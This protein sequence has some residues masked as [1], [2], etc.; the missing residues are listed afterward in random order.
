MR[1]ILFYIKLSTIVGFTPFTVNSLQAI[2]NKKATFAGGCFWCM[3]QPFEKVKGIVSVVSGYSG[4]KAENPNYNNYASK[5]YIEAI[6]ITYNPKII[7]Y[8]KLLKKF[9]MLIDPTD[10]K[11]QFVDRGY[12]YTTAIFFHNKMQKELAIKS[13]NRLIKSKRF[14]KPIVT[15]IVKFSKFYPAENYHQDFYKKNPSRYNSYKNG[16][17]RNEFKKLYWGKK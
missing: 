6:Q 9:W 4:G 16:S 5:G 1:K 10:A 15:P 7:S 3:E 14:H 8:Q 2:K 11:G 13:K 17:G 12:E